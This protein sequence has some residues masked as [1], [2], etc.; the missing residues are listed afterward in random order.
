MSLDMPVFDLK[1][2]KRAYY[3]FLVFSIFITA[4]S[5]ICNIYAK[6]LI[7]P[8]LSDKINSWILIAILL[9][10]SFW[11]SSKNKKELNA[12]E[13]QPV[14]NEKFALYERFYKKRLMWHAFNLVVAG[15][16][17]IKSNSQY[18]VYLLI[19]QFL[20]FLIGYP[21]KPLLTR[22]LKNNDIVFS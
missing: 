15:A 1:N 19:F 5:I 7:A 17:V 9:G 13:E 21:S 11:I 14:M 18:M 16:F 4:G 10:L 3:N 12:I 8:M 22:E 20:V 2:L 6:A